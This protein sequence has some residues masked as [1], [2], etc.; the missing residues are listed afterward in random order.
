MLLLVGGASPRREHEHAAAVAAALPDATVVEI[1]EARHV[2]MITAAA[3]F[4]AAVET[5]LAS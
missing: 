4:V 5:F 3:A 2:A 1:P